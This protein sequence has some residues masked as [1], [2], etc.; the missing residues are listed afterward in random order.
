MNQNTKE[1]APVATGNV[2]ERKIFILKINETNKNYRKYTDTV[3]NNW[4]SEMEDYGYEVEFAVDAKSSDIQ[5]EFIK[6]EIACAVVTQLLIEDNVLYGI[7]KFSTEGYKSEEIYNGTINL[8]D[9]VLIPKSKGEVNE[10]IVQDNCKLYGF[11]LVHKN[12]SSFYYEPESE[13]ALAEGDSEETTDDG[14]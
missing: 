9:C 7:T 3:V 5:Y 14:E 4:I 10:G 13:K 8:D 12:Q 11:N 2:I 6:N 1:S